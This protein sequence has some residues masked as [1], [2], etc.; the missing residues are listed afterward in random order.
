M[1]LCYLQYLLAFSIEDQ[2]HGIHSTLLIAGMKLFAL[3]RLCA[4]KLFTYKCKQIKLTG[5]WYNITLTFK[6]YY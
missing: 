2:Y 3:L 5:R 1:Y 6:K 4:K